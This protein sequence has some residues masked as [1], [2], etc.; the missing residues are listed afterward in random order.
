MSFTVA[1][2]S[3]TYKALRQNVQLTAS[4]SERQPFCYLSAESSKIRCNP[5][6]RLPLMLWAEPW[7]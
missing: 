5:D 3:D 4:H 2:G 1:T 6:D 7:S